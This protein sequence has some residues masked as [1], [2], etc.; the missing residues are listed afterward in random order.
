MRRTGLAQTTVAMAAVLAAATAAWASHVAPVVYGDQDGEENNPS[1]RYLGADWKELKVD[2]APNGTHS[3]GA[4]SFTIKSSDGSTFDWESNVGLDAVVVKG[5]NRGSNVYFYPAA[6]SDSGLRS[7]DN[8]QG[9]V[10]E[11]SHVSACYVAGGGQQTTGGG[12]NERTSDD[13][14]DGGGGN[15]EGEGG[16]QPAGDGEE[17]SAR[18]ERAPEDGRTN[19]RGGG[20]DELP[21]AGGDAPDLEESRQ[22][23]RGDGDRVDGSAGEEPG[24]DGSGGGS[25]QA[26]GD[27]QGASDTNDVPEETAADVGRDSLPFSGGPSPLLALVALAMVGAGAALRRRRA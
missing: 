21:D 6:K 11:V 2:G 14:D 15:P 16:E 23:A 5:G 7:P 8:T 1:C 18:E 17:E 12:Q 13:G 26:E 3:D 25:G 10:P 9:N 24:D 22:D 19:A 20:R 4:L 27:V